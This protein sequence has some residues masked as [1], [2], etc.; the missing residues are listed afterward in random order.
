[1]NP[2]VYTVVA[3]HAGEHHVKLL[4]LDQIERFCPRTGFLGI[5]LDP[6]DDGDQRR[7]YY[8]D[9][10]LHDPSPGQA[11]RDNVGRFRIASI[12]SSSPK[13]YFTDSS[14]NL[15]EGTFDVKVLEFSLVHEAVPAAKTM[16]IT[17][18]CSPC[19]S[20][21]DTRLVP[22][23]GVMKIS[24]ETAWGDQFVACFSE[25]VTEIHLQHW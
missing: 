9:L 10:L 18:G 1:M 8:E 22:V 17:M 4:S 3:H 12:L 15:G 24:N 2:H 7:E 14:A 21:Q 16:P 25:L 20:F 5:C 13:P 11:L 23:R 19:R 6:R